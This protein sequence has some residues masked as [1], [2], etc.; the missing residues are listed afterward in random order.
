MILGAWGLHIANLRVRGGH[1][2][3]TFVVIFAVTIR[4]NKKYPTFLGGSLFLYGEPS[5]ADGSNWD[6][7]E[8]V[9]RFRNGEFDG[10]DGGNP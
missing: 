2:S 9:E 10:P 7:L 4:R 5:M 3:V 6:V 1:G 8:F